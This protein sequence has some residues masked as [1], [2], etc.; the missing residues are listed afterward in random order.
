MVCI[1]FAKLNKCV[2]ETPR[3]TVAKDALPHAKTLCRIHPDTIRSLAEETAAL[4]RSVRSMAA[5]IGDEA[6]LELLMSRL[7]EAEL[8]PADVVQRLTQEEVARMPQR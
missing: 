3:T 8:R 7:R 6:L 2:I 4:L 1:T 5:D